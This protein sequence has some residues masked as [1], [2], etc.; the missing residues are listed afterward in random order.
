MQRE[1]KKNLKNT[2]EYPRTL[3][4]FQKVSLECQMKKK[5]K[6]GPEKKIW[7]NNGREFSKL[8][9]DIKPQILNT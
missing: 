1:K 2:K 9:I 4:L 7:N 8:T 6:M 5:Q 3:D